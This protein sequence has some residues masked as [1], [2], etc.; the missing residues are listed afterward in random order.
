M[1]T[2]IRVRENHKPV[3]CAECKSRNTF[4]AF[5]DRDIKGEETGRVILTAFRCSLCH[6]IAWISKREVNNV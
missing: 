4:E 2:S 3:F 1:L 6:H 5:P